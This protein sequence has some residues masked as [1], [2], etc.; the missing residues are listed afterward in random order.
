MTMGHQR[1]PASVKQQHLLLC[2]LPPLLFYVL[3][4][5]FCSLHQMLLLYPCC[6]CIVKMP[7]SQNKIYTQF[8]TDTIML[9]LCIFNTC[10]IYINSKSADSFN[11]RKTMCLFWTPS[12]S[13]LNLVEEKWYVIWAV[14]LFVPYIYS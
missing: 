6:C 4:S 5:T 12:F 14:V 3:L 7:F 9:F 10:A 11:Q 8:N 2:P 13:P 1:N